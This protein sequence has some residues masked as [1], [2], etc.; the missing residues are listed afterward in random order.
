MILK[1]QSFSCLNLT[2]RLKIRTKFN[3]YLILRDE[4]LFVCGIAEIQASLV[5]QMVK[6]W[7]KIH[8]TGSIPWWRRYSCLENPMKR[9]VWQATV[10]G[11]QR[12]RH[13][14]ATDTHTHTHTHRIISLQSM[15]NVVWSMVVVS[16][17]YFINTQLLTLASCVKHMGMTPGIISRY[18]QFKMD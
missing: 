3:C 1:A 7:L 9:G 4:N 8:E 12:V 18:S 6:N 10:Q 15:M 16:K 2:R 17:W 5:A 13:D 14:W 11:S